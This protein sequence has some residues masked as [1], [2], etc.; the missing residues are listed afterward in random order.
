MSGPRC[1]GYIR[2][3][4]PRHFSMSNYS[5]LGHARRCRTRHGAAAYQ[6]RTTTRL[7]HATSPGRRVQARTERTQLIRSARKGTVVTSEIARHMHFKIRESTWPS[8]SKPCLET[9][10]TTV[11]D[12][13][14]G[15]WTTTDAKIDYVV[16][17]EQCAVSLDHS[18][19]FASTVAFL[20]RF[21]LST[22]SHS[23][24]PVYQKQLLQCSAKTTPCQSQSF[25][26]CL[27][28][29]FIG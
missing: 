25:C 3:G 1:D 26:F 29:H 10:T 17:L 2:R 6:A 19:K 9:H 11:R 28:V 13:G 21:R 12:D 7:R 14:M 24:T 27:F 20:W 22:E 5:Y 23:H 8:E 18:R 4:L 16:R 15:N